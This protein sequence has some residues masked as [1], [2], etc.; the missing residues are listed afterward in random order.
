MTVVADTL[1]DLYLM[2][3]DAA[4]ALAALE[5]AIP[6]LERIPS[7][8]A[9]AQWNHGFSL[10]LM[11][12][13]ANPARAQELA[14]EAYELGRRLSA[15]DQ[16]HGTYGLMLTSY[17][18]GD[19][20]RVETLLAQH[21]ANPELPAGTRCIAVQSGPALGA[22]VLAHRGDPAR[23]LEVARRSRAWE[24]R[25][26]PVE[27]QIAEALVTA[28]AVAE[29]QALAGEVLKR[30]RSWRWHQ[31]AL[32]MLAALEQQGAW[33]E[34]G[35]F[36]QK[37]LP[38]RGGD[39]LLD[40]VAERST[41]LALAAQGQTEEARQALSRALAAFQRF[42]FV[43]EAARTQQALALVSDEGERQSLLREA[44]A[45]YRSLGAI[46]HVARAEALPGHS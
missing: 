39:H 44:I 2:E 27:G 3:G 33:D 40:A 25:P 17:W 1:S 38:L 18:L 12:L 5:P 37:V 10:K 4:G 36:V 6:F 14:K 22:L 26:G 11:S 30:A 8:A 35:A 20:D 9:R 45:A 7:P 31:A 34:V 21:L 29:G 41:G 42:P 23:A 24:D 28:G 43:F 16:G 46:P 13:T 19:W 32:A 15:H